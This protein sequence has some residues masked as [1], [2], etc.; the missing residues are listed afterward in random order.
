MEG[1]VVLIICAFISS[2][3]NTVIY[4]QSVNI[5]FRFVVMRWD[6]GLSCVSLED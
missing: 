2:H 3:F 1:I 6:G 5:D 4:F